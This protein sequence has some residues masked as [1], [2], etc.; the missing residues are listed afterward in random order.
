LC[1][2]RRTDRLKSYLRRDRF[3]LS[4]SLYRRLKP[5]DLFPE[6]GELLLHRLLRGVLLGILKVGKW[7]R[8]HVCLRRCDRGARLYAALKGL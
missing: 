4:D 2:E 7:R 3:V 1:A 6:I 8:D 5:G